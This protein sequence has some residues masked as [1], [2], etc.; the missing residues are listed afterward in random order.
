MMDPIIENAQN[1]ANTNDPPAP[2]EA[3]PYVPSAAAEARIKAIRADSAFWDNGSPKQR[4]LVQEL[5]GLTTGKPATAPKKENA[6]Q[7]AEA[8]RQELTKQ[9]IGGNLDAAKKAELTS[10]LRQLVAKMSTRE[11]AGALQSASLSDHRRTLGV[12][13]PDLPPSYLAQYES[14]Y[15]GHEADFLLA[16]RQEGLDPKLVAELRDAGIQ[17]AIAAEGRAVSDEAFSAMEKKF[18]GRLT[19]LQFTSLKKWWKSQVEGGGS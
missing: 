2:V 11:E 15:S 17:M 12:Q 13:P 5:Q 14:D 19:A 16:S 7:A 10:E 4:Q 3:P 1:A 6:N 18:A 8:R 9:I